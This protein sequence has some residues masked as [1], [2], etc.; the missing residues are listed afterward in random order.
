MK[1]IEGI[2]SAFLWNGVELKSYGVKVSWSSM[3]V[4]KIEGG[5]GFK[6]LTEWNKT[7]TLRHIF[8]LFVKKKTFSGLS[9]S[10]LL[11]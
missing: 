5:L 7:A 3:C 10:T 6:R 2:L 8:G 9:A 1:E 11:S 4:P